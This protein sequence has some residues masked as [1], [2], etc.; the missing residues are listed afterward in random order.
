MGETVPLPGPRAKRIRLGEAVHFERD[1]F[2]GNIFV[3][4]DQGSGYNALLVDVHGRHYRTGIKGATRNY[5][6]VEGKGTF[7]LD[8]EVY[9]VQKDDLYVIPDGHDYEY[10]GE[11]KLFEFNIPGTTRANET[12]LDGQK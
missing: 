2:S 4:T 9:Q 1:G 6:V 12:N 3:G 7:T 11:M 10:E 8:G 5:L